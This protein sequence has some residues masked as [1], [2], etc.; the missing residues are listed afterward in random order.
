MKTELAMPTYWTISKHLYLAPEI[1]SGPPVMGPSKK[2]RYTAVLSHAD[3]LDQKTTGFPAVSVVF[4]ISHE[5]GSVLCSFPSHDL[6]NPL[7]LES[8]LIWHLGVSSYHW[9]LLL[10]LSHQYYIQMSQIIVF[11]IH[12]FFGADLTIKDSSIFL[13]SKLAFA[14]FRN[15]NSTH[16]TFGV[17][18]RVCTALV[19]VKSDKSV[20]SF[21]V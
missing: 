6:E 10:L 20:L 1:N 16:L 3:L 21:L 13:H 19:F 18:T 11:K 15:S 17:V 7:V 8:L 14:K 2:V 9:K 5:L 12:S 4:I